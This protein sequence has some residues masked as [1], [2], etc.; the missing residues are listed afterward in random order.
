MLSEQPDGNFESHLLNAREILTPAHYA[1]QHELLLS[2]SLDLPERLVILVFLIGN[3]EIPVEDL[4][5]VHEIELKYASRAPVGDQVR[6]LTD[7]EVS[8]IIIS[9]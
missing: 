4:A 5:L 2:H 7:C 6:I 9:E 3:E 8:I 1:A